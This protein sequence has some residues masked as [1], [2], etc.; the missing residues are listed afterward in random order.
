[1]Q[2]L[3]S[4]TPSIVVI[5]GL[6][7]ISDASHAQVDFRWADSNGGDFNDPGNWNSLFPGSIPDVF[8]RT[9]YDLSGSYTVNFTRNELTNSSSVRRGNVVFDLGGNTYRHGDFFRR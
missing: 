4:K 3:R 2:T 6:I 8:V 5:V 7:W 9:V 1:M